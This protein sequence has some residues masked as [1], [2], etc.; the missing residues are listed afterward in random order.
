MPKKFSLCKLGDQPLAHVGVDVLVDP[1]TGGAEHGAQER[2][3]PAVLD[4]VR[5]KLVV[6]TA[7]ALVKVFEGLLGAMDDN[8]GLV[9]AR[10]LRVG[11][12][13]D[14]LVLD[15]RRNDLHVH[16]VLGDARRNGHDDG[17]V[18]L[19]HVVHGPVP[20]SL[21]RRCLLGGRLWHLPAVADGRRD[22]GL[23]MALA[24]GPQHVVV[25]ELGAHLLVHLPVGLLA[26]AVAV[27]GAVALAAATLGRLAAG[28]ALYHPGLLWGREHAGEMKMGMGDNGSSHE[29]LSNG[30]GKAKRYML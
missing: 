25:L 17:L 4:L 16:V 12:P 20:C 13:L 6:A 23:L 9:G 22:L 28:G 10:R 27:L 29:Q 15:A 1:E 3:L 14:L 24:V 8:A 19:E 21:R 7:L 26:V 5:R 11:Q 18:V 30:G 2:I